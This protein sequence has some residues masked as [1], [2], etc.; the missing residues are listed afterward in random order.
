MIARLIGY[1]AGIEIKYPDITA[2]VIITR[3][4]VKVSLRQIKRLSI[5]TYE[6]EIAIEDIT[7]AKFNVI[8]RW[9]E[10]GAEV[11]QRK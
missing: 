7:D 3:N 11:L 6:H 10:N 5:R 8:E 9:L 2:C 4:G 1:L